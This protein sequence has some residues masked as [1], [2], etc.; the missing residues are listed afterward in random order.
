MTRPSASEITPDNRS[1]FTTVRLQ[2]RTN[3]E[4]SF[5][6]RHSVFRDKLGFFRDKIENPALEYDD[7][8]AQAVH[9][10]TYDRDETLVA[11]ARLIRA[12]PLQLPI[13]GRCDIHYR[14]RHVF[15]APERVWEISRLCRVGARGDSFTVEGKGRS[16]D[17][18][19]IGIEMYKALFL[20]ARQRG[21]DYLVA[22]MER[23]LARLLK[24]I[25]VNWVQIGP[26]TDYYGA[27]Q[28]YACS[29]LAISG[30]IQLNNPGLYSELA[31]AAPSAHDA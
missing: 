21:A 28:P 26:S 22:A 25:P 12:E 13:L 5:G 16:R 14:Y 17:D 30:D 19:L 23:P 11:T 1:R 9:F 24:A 18:L 3:L 29:V 8:D 10:G 31:H 15:A 20:Y 4:D 27:V 2:S 6:L 7:Y